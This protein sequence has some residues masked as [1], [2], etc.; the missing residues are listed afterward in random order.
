MTAEPFYLV[1]KE[2]RIAWVFLNRPGKR[3]AMN[4]P[5]W[6]ELPAIMAELDRDRQIR[7][8]VIAGKV[9]TFIL[10]GDIDRVYGNAKSAE[11]GWL[12]GARDK[13]SSFSARV[14]S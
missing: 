10:N 13:A 6:R 7:A 5:A 4:P 14:A 9:Q 8:V 11:T 12:S 2:H 3:N 1:E